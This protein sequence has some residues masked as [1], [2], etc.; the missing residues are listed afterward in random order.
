MY[1]KIQ[2]FRGAWAYETDATLKMFETLTDESLEQVVYPGGRTLGRI[3]CSHSLCR[4]RY[5]RKHYGCR[6][7]AGSQRIEATGANPG[8]IVGCPLQIIQCDHCRRPA[9]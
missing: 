1:R 8:R 3:A 2:D 6:S 4:A 5:Y 9:G 7:S